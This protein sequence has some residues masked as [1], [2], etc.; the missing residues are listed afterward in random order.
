[1]SAVVLL[2]PEFGWAFLLFLAMYWGCSASPSPTQRMAWLASATIVF[3]WVYDPIFLWICLISSSIQ[4]GIFKC[5][6]RAPESLRQIL[7][8]LCVIAALSLLGIA[9]YYIHLREWLLQHINGITSENLPMIEL[10][11]QLSLSFFTF[12]SIT[13]SLAL[14]KRK[15]SPDF[16]PIFTFNGFIPTLTAGPILRANRFIPQLFK[17]QHPKFIHIGI[18]RIILGLFKK[19]VLAY[20]L[21]DK[22]VDPIFADPGAHHGIEIIGAAFAYSLQLYF[23]FSGLSDL[24][25]GIGLLLGFHIPRNFR[26]PY[27]ARNMQQ[28]WRRWH[29]SL[30]TWIRD[31]V[32][33]PLGGNRKGPGRAQIHLAVAML[34]SGLWHGP[35]PNFLIWAAIHV[36][37]QWTF[38]LYST[39]RGPRFPTWLGIALTF[40]WVTF[41]WVFFRAASWQDAI[42]MFS[43]M[44]QWELPR[45]HDLRPLLLGITAYFLS[46]R[47]SPQ[48]SALLIFLDRHSP[49]WLVWTTRTCLVWFCIQLGPTGVPNFIYANF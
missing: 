8:G 31:Y 11:N 27:L 28:F 46:A 36:G 24:V 19:L 7:T 3:A 22:W 17:P 12:Q 16:L 21:A 34:L 43:A 14:F 39:L 23:D 15:I 33:K 40:T 10:G 37:G 1:M 5:F 20:W 47:Y 49:A 42:D 2:S 38:N 6:N 30:S 44:T 41:A 26:Q 29:I 48:I 45:Q 18:N 4:W 32:Y 13:L 25:I 9:K 35:T